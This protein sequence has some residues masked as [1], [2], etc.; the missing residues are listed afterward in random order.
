VPTRRQTRARGSWGAAR[1][2][3]GRVYLVSVGGL[4][5]LLAAGCRQ[6]MQDQPKD[7]PLAAS[8][9]FA[10]G[11]ASR[12][13]LPGTVA[14]GEPTGA[15]VRETG[16]IDGAWA[17]RA[18]MPVTA[19]LLLRGRE[20]YD[21]FCAVCHDRAGTG[22]G[23]IVQRGFRQP[24]AFHVA[25][26]VDAPDG[27]FFDV[28]TNGFGV[29]PSHASQ[30]PV[31]DRWAITTYIRALQLSQNARLTD[32]PP[33]ARVALESADRQEAAPRNAAPRNAQPRNGEPR[34]TESR[35]ADGR[36]AEA[37]NVEPQ[38]VE[39]HDVVRTAPDRVEPARP[40]P[41]RPGAKRPGAK[42]PGPERRDTDRPMQ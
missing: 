17:P 11:R 8:T 23:M 32:V 37:R 34:D 16:R 36:D 38:D 33:A 3:D 29:M 24:Q 13:R 2:R 14:R 31:G 10:D 5:L 9:F 40:V 7:L 18:P 4:C 21:I 27:Y 42:R 39:P 30:I 1:A 19:D 6:D 26:L 20:R 25:R 22:Y 12:P 28:I 41:Q 15:G 35:D